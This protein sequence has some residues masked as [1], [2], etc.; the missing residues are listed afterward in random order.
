[1]NYS[2]ILMHVLKTLWSIF[3]K[4]KKIWS[5]G[6]ISFW[7]SKVLRLDFK[8]HVLFYYV[9]NDY[10]KVF[11]VKLYYNISCCYKTCNM[12]WSIISNHLY[13]FLFQMNFSK[14]FRPLGPLIGCLFNLCNGP[15]TFECSFQMLNEYISLLQTAKSNIQ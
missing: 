9:C 5:G 7:C 2:V 10:V 1:M 14:F 3:L 4:R 15:F 13:L 6:K 8:Y 12:Y 11:I